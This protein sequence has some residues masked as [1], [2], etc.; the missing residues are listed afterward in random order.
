[1]QMDLSP[2]TM[3]KCA[4]NQYEQE[5]M[6]PISQSAVHPSHPAPSVAFVHNHWPLL[7]PLLQKQKKANVYP[8]RGIRNAK[9]SRKQMKQSKKCI[10]I[11]NKRKQPPPIYST[12][13]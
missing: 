8:K 2:E 4:V 5:Y 10:Q 1:M 6:L 9:Q 3:N 12:P 7:L 13:G 11:Q